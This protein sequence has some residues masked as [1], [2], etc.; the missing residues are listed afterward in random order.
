MIGK[1]TVLVISIH[2]RIKSDFGFAKMYLVAGIEDWKEYNKWGYF[3]K[4]SPGFGSFG[5]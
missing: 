1:I 2:K 4:K 5:V 3:K